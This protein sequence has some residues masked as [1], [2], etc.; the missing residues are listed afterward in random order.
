M[1]RGAPPRGIEHD[2][3]YRQNALEHHPCIVIRLALPTLTSS[4]L[5]GLIFVLIPRYIPRVMR[6]SDSHTISVPLVVGVLRGHNA[7]V[8]TT[9][10][11]LGNIHPEG[12]IR[13]V[14]AKGPEDANGRLL[15]SIRLPLQS[16]LPSWQELKEAKKPWRD[17]L[18]DR[19][20]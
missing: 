9:A 2:P 18:H 15:R 14:I 5:G 12:L 20:T 19:V 16:K 1:A 10:A 8:T 3:L 7:S 4:Q 17:F 13:C 11:Q 6:S